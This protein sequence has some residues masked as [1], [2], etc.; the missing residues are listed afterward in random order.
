MQR[1][2]FLS[3]IPLLLVL[4]LG[5]CDQVVDILNPPGPQPPGPQ[6]VDLTVKPNGGPYIPPGMSA[7]DQALL[8]AQQALSAGG[9]TGY[10]QTLKALNDLLAQVGESKPPAGFMAAPPRLGLQ[11]RLAPERVLELSR[12]AP[13]TMLGEIQ[14][15]VE[16]VEFTGS[17]Q[18]DTTTELVEAELAAASPEGTQ[19]NIH[20]IYSRNPADFTYY[21]MVTGTLVYRDRTL[22]YDI[23]TDYDSQGNGSAEIRITEVGSS[24]GYHAKFVV[25][26]GL[27]IAG[28]EAVTQADGFWT[29][30]HFTGEMKT[31]EGGLQ[32]ALLT[33]EA[34]NG[35]MGDFTL[36]ADGSGTGR[37][38][39]ASDQVVALLEVSPL[40]DL[41]IRYTD[42]SPASAIRL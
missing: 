6:P 42:G 40:G 34:S 36:E 29:V 22:E 12:M 1:L 25:E 9:S 33:Y 35:Y 5:G 31:P 15:S 30:S 37:I 3:W 27:S 28:A 13:V 26:D 11:G 41:L 17:A 7:N 19:L 8:I 24:L 16:G 21:L 18:W 2:R 38:I 10:V 23:T 4:M 20:Q 39:D 32:T 14:T